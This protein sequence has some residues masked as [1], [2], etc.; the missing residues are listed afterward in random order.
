MKD[1]KEKEELPSEVYSI[2][3]VTSK[4]IRMMTLIEYGK[5]NEDIWP[6]IGSDVMHTYIVIKLVY[7]TWCLITQKRDI[8]IEWI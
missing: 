2:I 3:E 1:Y 5:E 6:I 4:C 8:L 7:W